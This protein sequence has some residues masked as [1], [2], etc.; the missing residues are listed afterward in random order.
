ML[1]LKN[2]SKYY[3]Q[4]GVIAE[5]FSKV[6]LELHI[7]E[8]VVITGE[9][10]SGKSTLLNVLSGLD[11]Y[12]DG[13]M[14]INGEE[15]SHYTEEDYLEYRRKYVSNIF[16]N[17]N[18]VNSYS[19][20]EN[21]ELAMLLNGCTKSECKEK[22][23]NLIKEVGMEKFRNAKV[24]K[25]SGGQKQRVAIARALAND[26]PIIVAD[27][28]TGALDSK[29]AKGIVELLSKISKNK[30]VIVVTHNKKEIEEYATRLI[31]MHDGKIL[32]NRVV[33]K[34]NDDSLLEEKELK[35][36]NE[37]GKFRLAL[38]NA[39]N[40]PV[41]FILMTV[42]FL[43]IVMA[44][45]TNYSSFQVAENEESLTSYNDYFYDYQDR[46]IIVTKKDKSIFS[47]E[48]YN[49]INSINGIDYLVKFDLYNDYVIGIYNNKM[50][51][52]GR[53]NTDKIDKVDVGRIPVNQNEVVIKGNKDNY[54]IGELQEEL[55]NNTY[56]INTNN[57]YKNIKIV[58]IIYNEDENNYVLDYNFEFYVNDYL[59]EDLKSYI[60]KDYIKT[61]FIIN[62]HYF[63]YRDDEEEYLNVDM[64]DGLNSG[65]CIVKDDLNSYCK[66]NSCLNNIVNI[67]VNNIYYEDS[68]ELN[69]KDI[70]NKNNS[71]NLINKKYEDLENVIF[72]SKE[73]YNRLFNKGNFQSSV[74]VKEIKDI[75][76]IKKDLN[77]LGYDTLV[78]RESKKDDAKTIM[79]IFKI[80]RLI[81]IIVLVVALFFISYFIIK[82]IYKSRNSYYTT[83]RTLGST[84]KV[85]INILR[86]EL[87]I[88]ATIS[89][90]LFAIFMIL[91]YKNVINVEFFK[92][93][94]LYLSIREYVIIYLILIF[95]SVLISFRYGRKV[96]KDSII[97]TYGEKI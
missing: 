2:V 85:C 13:E 19:V 12:E 3:Y 73:D 30:L 96:F 11:S 17:F 91:V 1:K 79:Q 89:Y 58:G 18:L 82:L 77:D 74:Y 9:S 8:F 31:T 76:N 24:S 56:S 69:V 41:K 95:V 49:K 61:K 46:R 39:F 23:N 92:E 67:K 54:Y 75:K 40:L 72:I 21:I 50:Y 6:S 86:K 63:G 59:K 93:M 32:E 27:E 78:L 16:Q 28:P 45:A 33:K 47:E 80:F 52:N 66:N 48:D 88:L 22:V 34:I 84:K 55:F 64:L 60:S 87:V 81:L 90:I 71:N 10:G 53:I 97:K 15:T 43:L 51:L 57:K 70:Y 68:L 4:N 25:L 94:I 29:S 37:I 7:G 5:G 83:L 20:Y 42:I 36:I 14:Y 62:N 26:T 44:L 38:K 65:E 35:S